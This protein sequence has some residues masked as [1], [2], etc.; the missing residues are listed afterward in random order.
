MH[1]I[2]EK[3]KRR[4][5]NAKRHEKAVIVGEVIESILEEEATEIELERKQKLEEAKAKAAE[6]KRKEL[7]AKKEQNEENPQQQVHGSNYKTE[8]ERRQYAKD[9]I[10]SG[11]GGVTGDSSSQQ[12]NKKTAKKHYNTGV[13]DQKL[14]E[15][16]FG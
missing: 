8:A 7:E 9:V 12:Q 5:N 15:D 14:I 16:L 11:G 13:S 4:Y 3:H 2:V 6:A 1:K 10:A